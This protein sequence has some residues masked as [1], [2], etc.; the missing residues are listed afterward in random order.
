MD[1]GPPDGKRLCLSPWPAS[2]P[3]LPHPHAH[4]TAQRPPH[5]HPHPPPPLPP[6]PPT[7]HHPAH[8]PPPPLPPPPP[9][10]PPHPAAAPYQQQPYP[11]QSADPAAPTPP[12]AGHGHAHH[13]QQQ[14]QQ[15]HSP[16]LDRRHREQETPQ[17]HHRQPSQSQ[18]RPLSPA[19]PHPYHQYPS[20]DSVINREAGEDLR[21]PNSTGHAPELLL[22]T[23]HP[24]PAPNQP[25]PPPPPQPSP[26]A[27]RTHQPAESQGRHMSYDSRAP[28]PQT[29]GVYRPSSFPPPTPPPSHH[30]SYEPHGPYAPTDPTIF[31][32]YQ[33]ASNAKKKNTRASQA[34][35]QCRQLKAKC[36]ETKPCKT[37]RDKGTECRYRDPVPKATDKAQADILEGINSM[38]QSLSTLISHVETM[39]DR[40]HK[41]ESVASLSKPPSDHDVRPLS[42]LDVKPLSDHDVKGPSRHSPLSDGSEHNYEPSRDPMGIHSDCVP[43]HVSSEDE[44]EAEPGPPVPPGEPAI[45]INH[46]TLAGLLLDWPPIQALTR[47][48]LESVGIR[49]VREYPISQEQ[50][51]G[52]LIVYGRGEDSHSMRQQRELQEHGRLEMCEES[53]DIASPPLGVDWGQVGGLSPG[54]QVEY[55]YKGGVLGPDGNP[56]FS[57]ST[58]HKY[59]QSFTDNI[60]NMHPVIQPKD[61]DDWVRQ[62][63]ESLPKTHLKSRKGQPSKSGV[64]NA[65]SA[66]ASE[67]TGMKRKRSSPGPEGYDG[68]TV[69]AGRPDRSIHSALILTILALGKVCLHR[70]CI[71]D[72]VHDPLPQGSPM[73]RNGVPASPIRGS[74]PSYSS[75]SHSSSL[76]SPREPERSA[77][78]RRSSIHGGV[79]LGYNLKKNYEQIPGLEYFAFATDILGNYIGA[80]KNMKLVYANIFAGLYQG[81]LGRPLESFSWIHAAG[82]K[83]QVIIRPSMDKLRKI[84]QSTQLIKDPKYN[85]IALAFWTCLQLESDLIAEMT[86]PP[87]GL[88][89]HE[90]D[91]P[92]PNMS[93]LEG[94]DQRVLDSYPGQLYLRTHLNTIHR[95]FYAPEDASAPRT[96]ENENKLRSVDY[97]ASAVS[98]MKWVARR[99]AFKEDDAPAGDILSARLRG[100]YWGAQVIT[101][102][103]FVRMILEF[104]HNRKQATGPGT[105]EFHLGSVHQKIGG[106]ATSLD[107][108]PQVLVLARKGIRALIEST[109]AFHGLGEEMRPI[110]TNVFGTA[111]A[112][113]GNMLVLAAAYKDPILREWI[114]EE[115]LQQLFTRTIQFLRQSATATS[116]LMIDMR[117]LEGLQ[118]DLFSNDGGGANSSFSS[119]ASTHTPKMQMA[120]PPPPPPSGLPPADEMGLAS[121]TMS[122][123]MVSMAAAGHGR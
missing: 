102:R 69:R 37:C 19:L 115:L 106:N 105:M 54:D 8:H 80:Y 110:I 66:F 93:L 59:V 73:N 120:V 65:T 71:P 9:P 11:P 22:P 17:D 70:T 27:S 41:L 31:G 63:L 96:H 94:V 46:T 23:T 12:A 78:S 76:A 82:H 7:A 33:S 85:Q 29:A 26:Y 50:N 55:Q 30:N 18:T 68:P 107:M 77:Q 122:G 48:H 40:I 13:H 36:D 98:G 95:L 32:V 83:L 58:V 16:D 88:L 1:S 118:R 75:H 100:K 81:Q 92:P 86:V 6:P 111:H 57:D 5:P 56:D 90:D 44:L 51:R 3:S 52:P 123:R 38:Q 42:D 4:S 119:S 20:R 10:P 89:S 43:R 91:M 25:P 14:Q 28:L 103:P 62:F 116:S 112:Q 117:I 49:H 47:H 109:R 74:P 101:Y 114:D 99:F 15:Q 45:P 2:A 24:L 104:N 87:S 79:R 67:T 113:W 97:L 61:L 84:K 60:L 72:A 53:S 64:P 121:A 108:D 21:R 35:D 34:C 39:N